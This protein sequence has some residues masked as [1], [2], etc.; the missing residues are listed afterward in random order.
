MSVDSGKSVHSARRVAPGDL[1]D[2]KSGAPT[3]M[4]HYQRP[5]VLL[6]TSKAREVVEL[7]MFGHG[8]LPH[9]MWAE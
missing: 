7:V 6:V 5:L 8:I 2:R 9:C 3:P 1:G 4:G